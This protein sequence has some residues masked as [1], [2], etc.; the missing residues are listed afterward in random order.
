MKKFYLEEIVRQIEKLGYE[1]RL[2]N[3]KGDYCDIYQ[4]ENRVC[5]LFANGELNTNSIHDISKAVID[6]REYMDN[7]EKASVLDILGLQGEYR[8]LLEF[9]GYVLVMKKIKSLKEND[10]VV[11]Q[12]SK[13]QLSVNYG[14]HHSD[15]INAKE[16]F[17]QRSGL[18][19][20]TKIFSEKQLK[21]IYTSLV[22][23]TELSSIDCGTERS[24]GYVLDRIGDLLPEMLENEVFGK[25]KEV[26]H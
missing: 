11:W 14:Q 4:G 6:T 2:S 10:F 16:D 26:R 13:D 23:F 9:N 19:S 18:I 21:L 17:A 3:S 24:I 5:I 8:K 15:Y 1:C 22:S 7:Y 20:R 25:Q 12:Y